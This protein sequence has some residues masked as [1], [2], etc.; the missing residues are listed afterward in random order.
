MTHNEVEDGMGFAGLVESPEERQERRHRKGRA[1]T[2]KQVEQFNR[3][4]DT[5]IRIA[6]EYQTP[7]QL[8][9]N[10]D[11]DYGLDFSEA[12]EMAYE[13]IQGEARAAVRG[14]RAVSR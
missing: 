12:I 11:R 8:R 3:M 14:V 9:R 1:M 4:R 7:D 5:L 10:A 13:N 2:P 6:R